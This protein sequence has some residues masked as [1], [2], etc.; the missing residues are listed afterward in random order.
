MNRRRFLTGA[1]ALVATP[2]AAAV[3]NDTPMLRS[4]IGSAEHGVDPARAES[5]SRGL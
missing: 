4:P 5:K 3:G 1:A 2:A